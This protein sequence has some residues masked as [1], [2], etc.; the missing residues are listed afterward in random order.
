[1]IVNRYTNF[2][3]LDKVS[4]LVQCAGVNYHQVR[5]HV[6]FHGCVSTALIFYK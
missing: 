5:Q 6:I 4:E 2:V 3:G 1:M